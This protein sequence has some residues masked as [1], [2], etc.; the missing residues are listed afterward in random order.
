[1]MTM[2]RLLLAA[3]VLL[4]APLTAVS[5]AAQD[6]SPPLP[7][8]FFQ[9]RRQA[10][11]QS[12]ASMAK[13]R[14]AHVIVL[15][16]ASAGGD[17]A[18][19]YQD[20][21]F[22]YLSGVSEAGAAMLLF[23]GTGEEELLV[24]PFN[25]FTAMWD[26]VRLAPGEDAA[27]STGFQEV[28]NTASLSRR[29]KAFVDESSAENGED[30]TQL[31]IWTLLQPQPNKTSTPASASGFAR[32]IADDRFDGR[33]TRE[34]AFKDKLEEMFGGA[35]VKD[36]GPMIGRLRAVKT[37]DEIEQIRAASA[38][39]AHGLAEAMKSTVPGIY[40]FQ[41]AAT[42]R[43]VFSR[44]GAG[45]DAY[46]AIVG[47]GLNGCILHYNKND[48][49]VQD[50]DLIVMDYGPTVHGYCTDVTRTFPA[51]GVFT[52]EQR[53]LVS[54]VYEVQQALIAQVKPGAKISALSAQCGRMLRERGY[55][56]DHGPCHHVGLAVHDLQGD[57]LEPGMVL[58]VE[59]G[60]YLR[61]K[62]MG[63]RIEDVVLV[64]ETG[65]ENLSGHLPASPD[66]IEELMQRPGIQQQDV[67]LD[68]K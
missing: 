7:P 61:D 20:H 13:P 8:E 1:M 57:E 36:V 42:A 14:E 41:I 29:L 39:A 67:G 5:L 3:S 58:T 40:E 52:P 26:G 47:S 53:K 50:G 12:V 6:P 22:Y 38:I 63:C 30:E 46:A 45:P 31:V 59:P 23:P 2:T 60:A 17:M 34:S 68:S 51:N 35:V 56:P 49:Q 4:A 66:A 43:Y 16:G 32:R 18:E 19:F 44:L 10:L 25:R 15:R 54:D 11:M 55:N 64:T 27:A 28:G 33:A 65:C 9:G 48:R 62:G 24:P 21:D 37:Q